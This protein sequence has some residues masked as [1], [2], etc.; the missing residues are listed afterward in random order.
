MYV[1][2]GPRARPCAW[3]GGR[4]LARCVACP[5]L[6]PGSRSPM[7]ARPA[8]RSRTGATR[9]RMG[10][11]E[12]S[13]RTGDS[14]PGCNYLVRGYSPSMHFFCGADMPHY[15]PPSLSGGA[16]RGARACWPA[17]EGAWLG[18]RGR[19]C[20][21]VCPGPRPR[22][23]LAATAPR[24]SPVCAPLLAEFF[25]FLTDISV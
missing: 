20:W 11:E 2:N 18:G 16:E 17:G 21:L 14:N 6:R 9:L 5:G 7:G 25:S 15:S 3:R 4:G 22:T 8:R 1:R 13:A 19:A 12:E 10:G 23:R 24:F